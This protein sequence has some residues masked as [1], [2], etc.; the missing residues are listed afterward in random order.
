[1]KIT[2]KMR[3]GARTKKE[4]SEELFWQTAAREREPAKNLHITQQIDK[5]ISEHEKNVSRKPEHHPR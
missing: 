3:P 2:P 1:M 4:I 5:A